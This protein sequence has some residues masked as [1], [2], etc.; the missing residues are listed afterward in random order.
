MADEAIF[1]RADDWILAGATWSVAA[2]TLDTGY[3]LTGLSGLNPQKRIRFTGGTATLRATL[4]VA[5]SA[6]AF[7]LPVSNAE[8]GTLSIA[9]GA[10]F[11]L[12]VPVPPMPPDGIP[13]TAVIQ[14]AATAASTQWD[15]SITGNTA[16]VVFG[17]AVWFGGTLRAFARNFKPGF[18]VRERGIK[19]ELANEHGA[20]FRQV[21][22]ARHRF[23]EF[24][25]AA[26]TAQ[27]ADL[28][29]WYRG[30]TADG[31][32][33]SLFWPDPTVNDAYVGAWASEYS[34]K[35]YVGPT[36][37]PHTG[38]FAEFPKGKPV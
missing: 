28:I 37:H 6:T 19:G 38:V 13:L 2:G 30:L 21:Y 4:P 9:N 10:G 26:T 3:T 35:M 33:G 36:Y 22:Q 34:A 27:A 12:A 1:Q 17:A 8:A 16:P 32:D 31:S 24:D 23:F 25:V 15:V 14:F 20:T 7:A 29:A 5:K 11:S 18:G